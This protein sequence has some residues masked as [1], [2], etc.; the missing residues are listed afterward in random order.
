MKW[1]KGGD[2]PMEELEQF[3]REAPEHLAVWLR[4]RKPIS[5]QQAA[6][7][8]D[9]YATA[10]K[11]EDRLRLYSGA[12]AP[13]DRRPTSQ[14]GGEGR[15]PWTLINQRCHQRLLRSL[16]LHHGSLLLSQQ[17]HHGSLRPSFGL[18][19]RRRKSFVVRHSRLISAGS[20]V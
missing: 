19:L 4:E 17:L 8:A 9:N 16:L 13:T 11:G 7:M 3:I 15:K 5:L 14:T 1:T 20:L 2:V 12:S 6:E 18:S 10:R